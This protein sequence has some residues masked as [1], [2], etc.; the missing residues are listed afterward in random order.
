VAE[1]ARV[2][3]QILHRRAFAQPG[4]SPRGLFIGAQELEH[5]RE[6][7]LHLIEQGLVHSITAISHA[8]APVIQ[9]GR[10]G[11]HRRTVARPSV[12]RRAISASLTSTTPG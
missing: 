5:V 2:V 4:G 11:G 8:D 12:K 9:R 6:R 3:V 1:E 10:L 7:A